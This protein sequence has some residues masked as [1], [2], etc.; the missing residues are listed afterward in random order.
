MRKLILSALCLSLFAPLAAGAD[1]L[2][3]EITVEAGKHDRVNVPVRATFSV[4]AALSD[5]QGTLTDAAGKSVPCQI[6]N[7]SLDADSGK[8]PQ[9]PERELHFILTNLKAGE[10][11]KYKLVVDPGAP[12]PK[13]GFSW[14]DTKC[15]YDELRRGDKPVLRYEYKAFDDPTD[16][17]LFATFNH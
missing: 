7:V 12:T 6:T 16:D 8:K 4:P 17:K 5:A 3:L 13:N 9:L 1:K 2:T 11:A 10:T 15:D 14:H